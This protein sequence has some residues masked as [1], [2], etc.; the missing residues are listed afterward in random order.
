MRVTTFPGSNVFTLVNDGRS[1]AFNASWTQ[2]DQWSATHGLPV[3]WSVS[4][5]T[6][7]QTAINAD[8]AC[9]LDM[10]TTTKP[11]YMGDIT[12]FPTTVTITD[13]TLDTTTTPPTVVNTPR[14]ITI[15]DIVRVHDITRPY[16]TVYTTTGET[17]KT[18]PN[19]HVDIHVTR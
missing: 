10:H 11:A 1:A 8:H 16:L 19:R 17:I 2:L 7:M 3:E 4:D 12:T 14:T 18:A 13:Q 9:A 5:G 15:I 6:A